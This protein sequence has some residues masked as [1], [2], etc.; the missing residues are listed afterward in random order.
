MSDL[1]RLLG[2]VYDPE[3]STP[4]ADSAPAWS[5]DGALD[6]AFANWVPGGLDDR[7]TTDGPTAEVTTRA[8]P[9]R[10]T[11]KAPTVDQEELRAQGLS[12]I[13]QWQVPTVPDEAPD[14]GPTPAVWQ[15][16]DDDVLPTQRRRGRALSLHFGRR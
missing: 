4:P 13:H 10:E 3:A 6:A 5:N 15:R 11:P 1:S 12:A 8:V 9:V 2:D 16:S 14:P 7:S